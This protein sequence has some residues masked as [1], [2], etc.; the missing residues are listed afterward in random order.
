ME[1]GTGGSVGGVGG[2]LRSTSTSPLRDNSH[3][4]SASP[5]SSLMIPSGMGRVGVVGGGGA[6]GG[7]R[8]E[9]GIAK[10]QP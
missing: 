10:G 9:A 1:N 5:A 6:G 3:I 2:G 4:L 8:D 7:R